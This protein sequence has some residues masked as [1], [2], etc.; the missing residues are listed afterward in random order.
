MTQQTTALLNAFESLPISEKQAFA[1]E[2]LRRSL[3]FDSGSIDDH[4]IGSASAALFRSLDL[5]D[6]DAE[7]R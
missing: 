2:I 7:T 5:N 4:E 3:L 6:D 1:D